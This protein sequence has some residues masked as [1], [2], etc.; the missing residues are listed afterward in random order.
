LSHDRQSDPIIPFLLVQG[1]P[2]YLESELEKFV[3]HT[4]KA[5]ARFI[6]LNNRLHPERRNLLERRRNS[7]QSVELQLGIK[8]RRRGDIG[9]RLHPELE[10]HVGSGLDRR[11]RANQ[12]EQ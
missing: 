8:R 7:G 3:T 11:S 2:C 4:L 6:R 5:S 1:Q 12:T 9:L 10:N